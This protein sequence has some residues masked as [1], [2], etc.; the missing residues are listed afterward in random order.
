MNEQDVSLEEYKQD[1][2]FLKKALDQKIA[3]IKSCEIALAERE[4]R[5]EKYRQ[6]AGQEPVAWLSSSGNVAT[7]HS[8][9]C[10]PRLYKS[11]VTPLFTHPAPQK[12][13]KLSDIVLRTIAVFRMRG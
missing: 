9:K 11:H 1:A 10:Y 5:L 4:A 13:K 12:K 3:Q 8:K 6:E 7:P 2:D